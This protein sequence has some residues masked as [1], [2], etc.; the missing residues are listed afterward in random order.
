MII[1]KDGIYIDPLK[2]KAMLALPPP[3]NITEEGKE[4]LLHCF[5]CNYAKKTHGFIYLLK[6]YTPFVW[7]DLTQHAFNT[8]KHVITHAPVLEPPDYA[9]YYS[10]YVV[11]S[12]I[13]IGMVFIQT[14]DNDQENVIY[15]LRVFLTLKIITHMPRS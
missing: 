1:S 9:K 2:I 6:N 10:L 15:F 3:T 14:N 7:D 13:T 8:L 5:V 12:L 11:S 4:N